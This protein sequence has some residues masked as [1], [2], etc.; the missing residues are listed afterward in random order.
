MDETAGAEFPEPTIETVNALKIKPKRIDWLWAQRIAKRKFSMIAGEPGL[1]K[2]QLTASLAAIKSIGGI[3]PGS[4]T[5]CNPGRVVVISCEDDAEDTVVPRLLAAEAD[6]RH[7][8]L[9]FHVNDVNHDGRPCRRDL[10]LTIDTDLVE[11]TLSS[12][13]NLDLVFIDPIS[14]YL[15]NIDS[16]NNA[17]V[18]ALLAPLGDLSARLNAAIVGITHLNK[19]SG[20]SF[21]QRINGSSAFAAAPRA[22]F[23]VAKDPNDPDRRLFLPGKIIWAKIGKACHS[24]SFRPLQKLNAEIS[25]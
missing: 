15:G 22:V 14:A 10:D 7:I 1:G 16:H 25:R 23:F 19:G 20:K 8:D 3:F 17:Q 12:Y 18:R 4:S 6:L 11:R 2:S 24:R 9:I 5:P 13:Q 21:L